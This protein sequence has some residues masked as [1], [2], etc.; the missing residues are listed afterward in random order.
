MTDK[1]KLILLTIAGL[2]VIALVI[3]WKVQNG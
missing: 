1:L 2:L 3:T